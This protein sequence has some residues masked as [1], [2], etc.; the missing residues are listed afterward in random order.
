MAPG[1]SNA[2]SWR[3]DVLLSLPTRSRTPVSELARR[4]IFALALLA[5]TTFMVWF[6]RDGY[7]DNV[8]GDGVDLIDA[9]Y[10]A[11]VTITTTGYGDITPVT[12]LARTLAAIVIT[13]MRIVFLALLVGTTLEVLANEGRRAMRDAQWRKQQMRSH[14]VVVGYGS[15][16]QSAVNTLL[17]HGTP[18]NKIV[19]I[20][21]D[22][23]RV[24]EANL[25]GLAALEGDAV[26]RNILVRAEIAKARE[27]IVTLDRD[28]STILVVLTARQLN[29]RAHIVAAVADEDNVPLV[30]QSGASVVV[31]SSDA[32]G[33]LLGLSTVSPTMGTVMEDLLSSGEGIEV[34]QRLV[35]PD[36]VGKAP[37]EIVDERVIAVVRRGVARRFFDE[38][39]QSLEV[40]DELIVVRRSADQ[41]DRSKPALR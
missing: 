41:A 2:G 7:S 28:D 22:E 13:P 5:I 32:V 23:R 11:T 14:T 19:V 6:D 4:A 31:T 18:E 10:Y 3:H 20:E 40:G 27:V 37:A 21:N 1:R 39:V 15:K 30:R 12:P 33:R 17:A 35:A 34:G 36:E 29:P 16:G 38:A 25:R 8:N 9:L 24:G 26:N